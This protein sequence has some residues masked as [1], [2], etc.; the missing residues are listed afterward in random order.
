MMSIAV[1]KKKSGSAEGE[2]KPR[3]RRTAPIQVSTDLARMAAVV[4]S[5][6]RITQ[7]ELL[8]PLLRPFLLA[9]YARVRESI[10]RE[11]DEQKP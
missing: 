9:Q 4:A 11:L 5:H 8:E 3:V 2:P 10:D 1:G 7:A 6:D